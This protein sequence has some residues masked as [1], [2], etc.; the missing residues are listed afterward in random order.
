[1]GILRRS[2]RRDAHHVLSGSRNLPIQAAQHA[3]AAD[4][5]IRAVIRLIRVTPSLM[6]AGRREA[7]R[8]G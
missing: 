6:P 4:R 2:L 3:S 7:A 5:E 8:V 1:M